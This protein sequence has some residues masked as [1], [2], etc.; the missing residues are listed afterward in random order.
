M[1]LQKKISDEMNDLAIRIIRRAHSTT[2]E[3]LR[4][5]CEAWFDLDRLFKVSLDIEAK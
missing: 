4:R 1:S 3:K 2:D 5:M